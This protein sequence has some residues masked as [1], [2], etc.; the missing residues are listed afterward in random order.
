LERGIK[1]EASNLYTRIA[2]QIMTK[3]RRKV[4]KDFDLTQGGL[5][6]AGWECIGFNMNKK[7][8]RK[9]AVRSY[10]SGKGK[11]GCEAGTFARYCA[12]RSRAYR[13]RNYPKQ[14]EAWSK[15]K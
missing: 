8:E 15:G 11:T 3:R 6:P 12:T 1:K 2:R 7:R 14:V 10:T 13:H 9:R 4:S 5:F